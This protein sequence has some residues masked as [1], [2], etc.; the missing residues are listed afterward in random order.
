MKQI[1]IIGNSAAGISCAEAIREYDQTSKIVMLSDEDTPSYYRCL[2][3]YYLAGDVKKNNLMYKPQKF[4][5]DKNI[6]LV[7]NK[8]VIRVNT[9]KNRV[10]CEDKSQY[11]YDILVIAS[12][13]RAHIPDIKGVRKKSVFVFRSLKDIKEIESL[14]PIT[15]TA[16]VLGGGLVGIKAA[17]ALRRR[18]VEVKVL[19]KSNQILS[20]VL[21]AEAASLVQKRLEENGIEILLGQDADEIIGEGD[22]RAVKITSGKIFGCSLVVL[23]KGVEPAVDCVEESD[24]KVNYGIV[25]NEFLQSSVPNVFTAGDVCES[26]DICRGKNAVNA[27]WPV[28]VEQGRCAGLNISGHATV[29]PGSFGMNST[30][31][32]GLPVVSLGLHRIEKDDQGLEE[33]KV[34]DAAQGTYKKIIIRGDRIVGAIFVGAIGSSGIFTRLI[35]EQVDISSLRD[36]LLED[37]FGYPDISGLIQEKEQ[38]YV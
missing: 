23:G 15:K 6:E 7:L 25:G 9:K 22:I 12:G 3:S 24:I 26:L 10:S 13:A 16:C 4:Y 5:S 29:Y 31:F 8:K 32:F 27:I 2:I 36:K 33:C 17:Y 19:V 20:Q 37:S 21:D 28:A 38:S 14:L 34:F 1:L 30:D 35:K 11:D 18:N